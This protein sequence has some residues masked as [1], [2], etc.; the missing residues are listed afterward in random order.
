MQPSGHHDEPTAVTLD[1]RAAPVANLEVSE[2]SP[3]EPC[4]GRGVLYDQR[5]IPV[6]ELSL[7]FREDPGFLAPSLLPVRPARSS[8]VLPWGLPCRLPGGLRRRPVQPR[9][10]AWTH[11]EL[12][13]SRARR[14][15]FDKPAFY[16]GFVAKGTF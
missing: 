16:V 2:V 3:A 5:G 9:V 6:V 7:R 10:P 4:Q 14:I 15:L 8:S 12:P 11:P 1:L 13:P